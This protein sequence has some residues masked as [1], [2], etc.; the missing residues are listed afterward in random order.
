MFLRSVDESS[1]TSTLRIAMSL[2]FSV[3]CVC[4]G[5]R[6]LELPQLAQDL[7]GR[8]RLG[9]VAL[10][11]LLFAPYLVGFLAF[12]RNEYHRDVLG[13]GV[14]RDRPARLEA[15]HIG[16]DDVEQYRVRA[17]GFRLGQRFLA[18]CGREDLIAGAGDDLL[19]V[20]EIG[21]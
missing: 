16:H 21:R 18:G 5:G 8:V 7:I 13:V 4:L 2:S 6:A 3:T 1:A 17:L 19:Q 11:T 12:A 15:V 20:L 10:R 9:D 14:A